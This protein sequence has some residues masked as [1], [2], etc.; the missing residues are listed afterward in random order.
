M[1]RTSRLLERHRSRCGLSGLTGGFAPLDRITAVRNNLT[2]RQAPRAGFCDAQCGKGP[3]PHVAPLAGDR[4]DE[5][6]RP[7]AA[8]LGGA[9][10]QSQSRHRAVRDGLGAG[11]KLPR[12]QVRNHI[13]NN[14]I[15]ASLYKKLNFDFIRD[16]A[17]VAGISRAPNVMEVIPAVPAK[18]VPEF[19]TYAKA[20]PGRINFA[21]TGIGTSIHLSGELFNIMTGVYMVHLPYRGNTMVRLVSKN[22]NYF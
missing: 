16:I 6:Q 19:I 14:A 12:L 18:T 2:G 20:N 15:A 9:R 13:W 8:A 5:P 1:E 10:L 17:P 4:R 7:L 3:Q 22:I 11:C 21:S